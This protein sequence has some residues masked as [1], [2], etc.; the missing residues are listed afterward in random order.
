MLVGDFNAVSLD[1]I[2]TYAP[3]R[4]GEGEVWLG[5]QLTYHTNGLFAPVVGGGTRIR[6]AGYGKTSPG[7]STDCNSGHLP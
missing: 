5:A 1:L 7:Y 4:D 2:T 6:G 3:D